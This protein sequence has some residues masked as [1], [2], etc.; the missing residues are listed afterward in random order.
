QPV[1][2]LVDTFGTGKLSGE[3][4]VK[5]VREAFDL[6]P[7]GIID[8]LSLKRPIFRATAAYGHFGRPAGS[9]GSFSWEKTDRAEALG[10]LAR[11]AA[12]SAG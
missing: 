5:V 4:L 7:K 1:S 11:A 3:E 9:D 6:R 12:S 8:A 10:S 2:I